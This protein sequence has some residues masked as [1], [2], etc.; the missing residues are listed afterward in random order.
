MWT[1]L[2]L[3]VNEEL[4]AITKN[5]RN[6]DKAAMM[7]SLI[8]SEKYSCS[9][10]PLRFTKGST[11]MAGRSGIGR[12]AR[13]DSWASACARDSWPRGSPPIGPTC[14]SPTKRRPLRAMVRISFWLSPLSPTALRAALMRLVKGGVGNDPAT[15]NRCN[16]VVLADHPVAVLNQINQ[17]V[18]Y[19]R[20]DGNGLGAAAQ[21]APVGVK[22]MIAKEKLHWRPHQC[23]P[24]PREIIKPASRTNQGPGKA[25]RA[26]CRYSPPNHV[27]N[28]TGD[29]DERRYPYRC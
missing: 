4:R 21:F 26:S 1:A 7:S 28:W 10:S 9:G 14:T 16:Q 29:A 13:D 18:E 2:P 23:K 17:Q 12:A 25:F 27:G 11:A 22:C 24:G 20:L 19:L 5:Q 6:F 15:P 3:N 8:P